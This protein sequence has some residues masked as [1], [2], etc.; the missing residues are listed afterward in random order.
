MG[1]D[2]KIVV[3]EGML[4]VTCEFYPND[5]SFRNGMRKQLEAAL[6]WQEEKLIESNVEFHR[7]ILAAERER[8]P[9][10]DEDS[11]VVA[12]R[13]GFEYGV[14]FARHYIREMFMGSETPKEVN[15][16]KIEAAFNKALDEIILTHPQIMEV[17]PMAAGNARKGIREAIE[18]LRGEGQ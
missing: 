10:S 7:A 11:S 15:L 14:S 8:F 9:G 3:P 12:Q 13:V 5:E 18:K 4:D 17:Y 1:N 16:S 6:R 2:S